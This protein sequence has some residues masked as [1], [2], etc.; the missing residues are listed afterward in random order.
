MKIPALTSKAF[1]STLLLITASCQQDR[2]HEKQRPATEV[3]IEEIVPKTIPAT[4]EFVGFVQSSHDVEIRA[5]VSGY[6]DSIDYEE[7]Q[8]VKEGAPLFHID[9]RPYDA[10]LDNAKAELA[11]QEA[12][13]WESNRS[14]ER[15]KPLYEKNAASRR[16]LDNAISQ[17]LANT[18]QVDASKAKIR[19]AE[20]NLAYTTISA[21][22]GG[23]AGASKVRV[24]ALI[25]S[26]ETLLTTISVF[27]PIWVNFSI[28]EKDILQAREDRNRNLLEFPKDSD[29]EIEVTLANGSHYPE[30]GKL[31]FLS[32]TYDP[33]T[34]T[35]LMRASLPN[36]EAILR[37]GQFVRVTV[38]GATWPNAIV[39]PQRS[40]VQSK[41]GTYV[42]VVD[43]NHQVSVDYVEPGD[44][45]GDGWIIKSGLHEGQRV[46]VDGVNKVSPGA[47]V[48]IKSK[49]PPA[50]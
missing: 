26:Q 23:L 20:L 39:V 36:P 15:L 44:W 11:R 1:L 16:D 49:E 50:S 17:E 33:E 12:L 21:P 14:V 19:Q 45:Y 25:S 3:T 13:L 48:K 31:N 46:I 24:G 10:A 40:V 35:M 22:V 9:S 42:Y 34:G 27:D 37:P 8:F 28:S 2:T 32:P 38:V 7:G 43:N 5:R 29:F 4:Y 30:K 47:V 18:A 6:L 41:K